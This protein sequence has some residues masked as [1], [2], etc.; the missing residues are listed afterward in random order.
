MRVGISFFQPREFAC[1]CGCG[2]ADMALELV[3]WLEI[4]RRAINAPLIVTSGF[5]CP[6]HNSNVGGAPYSRHMIGCAADVR[7]PLGRESELSALVVRMRQSGWELDA[8]Q[9]YLHIGVPRASASVLW[10]GA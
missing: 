6:A 3:S 1:R 4:L 5:R 2:R 9:T 8:R 10:K 7:Y